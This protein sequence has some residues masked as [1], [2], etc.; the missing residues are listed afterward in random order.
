[1]KI[2]GHPLIPHQDF[3]KIQ[4]IQEISHVLPNAMI[5]WE[6]SIDQ[7]CAL[8]RFC[9]EHQIPY[10]VEIQS[11]RELLIYTNLDAKYLI[12]SKQSI[13]P[14]Q[15]ILK[16]YVLDSLLLC[17]ITEENEIENLALQGIDGVIFESLLLSPHNDF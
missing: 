16:E 15:S 10:A 7:N 2:I 13:L 17:K 4:T 14:F 3:S 8:A 6:A 9:Q 11:L 1:M 12:A 5:W